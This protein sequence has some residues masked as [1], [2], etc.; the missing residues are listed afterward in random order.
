[1]NR[2]FVSIVLLAEL[3]APP[4]SGQR[5]PLQAGATPASITRLVIDPA[6][7]RD[8][9]S[10][11][12]YGQFAEHLGHGIYDGVWT[13]DGSGQWHLRDV[14]VEALRRIRVPNVR[15][16]GGCF[17]DYYHW[18]DGIGPAARRPHMVNTVWGN[19]VED[20]SFGTDEYMEL[21]RRIGAEPWVVGN[22]GTGSPREMTEWWEYLNHPGGSTLAD[23]RKANGHAAPYNVRRFGVGNESWGCGGAMRP[24][25]YA[26]NYRRFAE[27]LRS[28]NDSTRPFRIA[29]GPNTGDYNW[30]EVVMREAGNMIDGLDLHYYTVVGPWAHKGS[31]TQFGEREWFLAMKGALRMEELV[32]RHS[33][34]MDKYDP[35]KR[36]ALIVGEW[37]MWH[38]VEPG[39]NPGFLNQQ[40]TLRDALVAAISLDIFNHHADRVRG[41]NIAQM[42][43]VLQ[44]MILTRGSQL[45]LTPTYHVFEMYTVHHDAVLVPLTLAETGYYVF[46]SDSVPAVSA[47][48][49]RDRDGV[50]H[51]TMSNV[52]PDRA[53]TVVA[54]LHG[55][56]VSGATGR[57]LAAP[58][59]NSYNSFERP[60][61]VR[62]ATFTGARIADGRLTVLLP[63]KSIVALELR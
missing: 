47:T 24:E 49:S 57:I 59:I 3:A 25:F 18:R 26:D 2:L 41:A 19:V 43:N 38:D 45:V 58:A 12:I 23:E 35:R 53:R 21:V 46:G 34:I 52:D 7:G 29:T 42:V 55:M 60:D 51:L 61:V 40:N 48:A 54:D 56:T 20:N 14:V 30:T 11:H 37:G 32:T 27:F 22:V 13:K 33:A 36:V 62:P 39:T 6:L 8:T 1:M 16:P 31:A 44:S 4:A 50:V 10:R 17:A 9:I 5:A 15:W 63:P 28:F